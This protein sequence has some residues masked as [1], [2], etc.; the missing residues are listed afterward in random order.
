MSTVFSR[1][2]IDRHEKKRVFLLKF[3]AMHEVNHMPWADCA[4]IYEAETGEP[5]TEDQLRLRVK[6]AV[7]D[8]GFVRVSEFPEKVVV[9]LYELTF[10]GCVWCSFRKFFTKIR[11]FF[12]KILKKR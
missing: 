12:Q 9:S 7:R 2:V 11:D 10:F 1:A 3:H 5:V 4:A 8:R 6:R